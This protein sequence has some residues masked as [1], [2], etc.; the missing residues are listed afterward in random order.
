MN[1]RARPLVELLIRNS[2]VVNR[3]HLKKRLIREN[4]LKNT[5]N[6]CG[7]GPFWNG[8]PLTLEMDHINGDNRDNRIDN[9][10]ILCLN[11]HSQTPTFRRPKPKKPLQHGFYHNVCD[12]II[13][14]LR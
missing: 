11:C 7:V 2:P 14:L 3:T 5:C 6:S 12:I 9:L 1:K 4:Y 10:R 8:R 13:K